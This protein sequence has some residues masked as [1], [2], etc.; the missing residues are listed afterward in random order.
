[1]EKMNLSDNQIHGPNYIN[2]IMYNIRKFASKPKAKICLS[3][4]T[5]VIFEHVF[6]YTNYVSNL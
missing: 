2:N 5:L 6:L 1:M 3:N 4:S